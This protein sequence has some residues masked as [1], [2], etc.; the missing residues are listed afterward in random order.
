MNKMDIV[1]MIPIMPAWDNGMLCKLLLSM[2]TNIGFR[3]SIVDRSIADSFHRST[4]NYRRGS[5]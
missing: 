2:L 1:I 4:R 5:S 3:V